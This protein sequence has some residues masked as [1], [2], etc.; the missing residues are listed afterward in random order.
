VRYLYK[1][2]LVLPFL[3]PSTATLADEEQTASAA[4]PSATPSTSVPTLAAQFGT[5]T[6]SGGYVVVAQPAGTFTER[7]WYGWQ[8][9]IPD[10]VATALALTAF[11]PHESQ[12]NSAGVLY[13]SALVI[14]GLDGPILHLAHERYLTALA[15]LGLRVGSAVLGA[16]VGGVIGGAEPYNNDEDVPP[17]LVGAL[18]GFGVGAGVGAFI[19]DAALAWDRVPVREFHASSSSEGD[20][21]DG[22]LHLSVAPMLGPRRTGM[23]LTGTF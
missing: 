23:G 18:I 11:A 13:A 16:F 15:S 2:A 3:L 20:R 14:F 4:A 5:T 22:G 6:L 7:R 21:P 10:G 17:G 12:S 8:I 1:L 9:L 19:D